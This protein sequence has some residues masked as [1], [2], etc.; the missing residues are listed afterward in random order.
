M[1]QASASVLLAE[2][3]AAQATTAALASTTLVSA[4]AGGAAAAG[5]AQAA[6]LLSQFSCVA[7][8]SRSSA[9]VGFALAPLKLGDG[10]AGALLGYAVLLGALV[11]AQGLVMLLHEVQ[12]A[13]TDQQRPTNGSAAPR[14]GRLARARVPALTVRG[15]QLSAAGVALSSWAIVLRVVG[16]NTD[17]GGANGAAAL[18]VVW[19][20]LLFGLLYYF[21]RTGTTVWKSIVAAT[22]PVRPRRVAV[23]DDGGGDQNAEGSAPIPTPGGSREEGAHV[24]SEEIVS[25]QSYDWQSP[26]TATDS[27]AMAGGDVPL[28]QVVDR[29]EGDR[30][31]QEGTS[32]VAASEALSTSPEPRGFVE[33]HIAPAGYWMKTEYQRMHSSCFGAYRP[34]TSRLE[35]LT[36]ALL[37]LQLILFA[38][39]AALNVPSLLGRQRCWVAYVAAAVLVGFR[40][41]VVGWTRPFR[42]PL[43]NVFGC[44]VSALVALS[45]LLLAAERREWAASINTAAMGLS[46]VQTGSAVVTAA[47]ERFRWRPS[48][49]AQSNGRRGNVRAEGR[50][51]ASDVVAT[52]TATTD[53]RKEGSRYLPREMAT[54]NPVPLR[55]ANP[56]L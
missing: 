49:M 9:S 37:L 28:L 30:K 10:P 6:A 7:G 55:C 53:R 24:A 40:S 27:S 18:G 33:R 3:T 21:G 32:A 11:I 22:G 45:A 2:A 12:S 54:T 15:F 16:V 38:F 39:V 48:F 34:A 4:L 19:L 5:D 46:T 35:A 13:N 44:A 14:M 23:G 42:A 51:G 52:G 31:E 50:G 43:T 8:S 36:P 25:W 20:A 1:E 26:C 56:L 17:G 29:L 47:L 41:V